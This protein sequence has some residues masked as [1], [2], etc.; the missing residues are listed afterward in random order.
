[1]DYGLEEA[2]MMHAPHGIELIAPDGGDR[3]GLGL[4]RANDKRRLAIH[5]M[6]MHAQDVERCAVIGAND[7]RY[8]TGIK[9]RRIYF[10]LC[11]QSR[12]NIV[13]MPGPG[14]G[15]FGRALLKLNGF[16]WHE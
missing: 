12:S 9:G 16:Y 10:L 11:S 4:E 8:R 6:R 14:F 1:M 3:Q 7:S 5:V 2:V 15:G 13:D